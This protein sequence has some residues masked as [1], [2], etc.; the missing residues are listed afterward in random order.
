MPYNQSGT[1]SV[2]GAWSTEDF[3]PKISGIIQKALSIDPI[4]NVI[5]H[6]GDTEKIVI[7]TTGAP[8]DSVGS[9]KLYNGNLL[10]NKNL[11]VE[12]AQYYKC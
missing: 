11:I 9:I 5:P 7:Q 8:E 3:L 6:A 4:N 1:V 10:E 12:L 2:S